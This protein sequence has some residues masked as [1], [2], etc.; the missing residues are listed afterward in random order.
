M[1]KKRILIVDD[2]Q[3][4]LTMLEKSLTSE[5]YSVMTATSAK[6]LDIALTLAQPDFPD[7]IILDLCLPDMDGREIAARIEKYPKMNNSPVMYL[8]A[9]F[10]K[11]E[12]KQRGQMLAGHV[13]FA[14][15]YEMKELLAMIEKLLRENACCSNR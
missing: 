5:G 15:P 1:D 11:E 6:S 2:E 14:K 12:E 4:I 10:S 3:D 8:T 7:L 13:L 9:R